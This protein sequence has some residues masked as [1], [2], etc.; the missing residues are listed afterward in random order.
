[1]KVKRILTR[2][3]HR[4]GKGVTNLSCDWRAGRRRGAKRLRYMGRNGDRNLGG[5]C[6]VAKRDRQFAQ[7]EGRMD[8][9]AC[10]G[11]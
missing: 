4:E 9:F 2:L 5:R 8:F 3:D 11:R 10:G 7:G 1:M 6:G